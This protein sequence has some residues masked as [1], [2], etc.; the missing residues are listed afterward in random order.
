[1]RQAAGQGEGGGIRPGVVT[2]GDQ[3]DRSVTC[4]KRHGAEAGLESTRQRIGEGVRFDRSEA[5]GDDRRADPERLLGTRNRQ[6][7]RRG[8]VTEPSRDVCRRD[9]LDVAGRGRQRQPG[10]NEVEVAVAIAIL[11]E[12]PRLVDRLEAGRRG[13]SLLRRRGG[14]LL[15]RRGGDRRHHGAE[16]EAGDDSTQHFGEAAIGHPSEGGNDRAQGERVACIFTTMFPRPRP[17]VIT[18]PDA[19]CC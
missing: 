15:R 6:I 7:H 17:V 10:A 19:G 13:G 12:E 3:N 14:G 16:Q 11:E 18:F 5:D 2:A 8:L 1:M 9:D 4:Q